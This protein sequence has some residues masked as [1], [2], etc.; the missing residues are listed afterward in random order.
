[1]RRLPGGGADLPRL[2]AT[3]HMI[4]QACSSIQMHV[5][6]AEAEKVIASLHESP[7]PYQLCQFILEN[8][9]MPNARFQAAA[10]IR[11]AALREWGLL[12]DEDKRS[13]IVFCLHF[14]MERAGASD[15]YVQSKVSAVA[16]Q[17]IKRGWQD[18]IEGDKAGVLFEVKQAILGIY[19]VDAQFVGINFLESLV[20]EFSPSTSTYMGLPKEFHELCQASFEQKYLKEF[21]F[22]G[23][24]AAVSVGDKIIG[25]A[26]IA[27]PE[28]KV[29]AAALLLMHQILNWSFKQDSSVSDLSGNKTHVFSSGIRH[30]TLLLKKFD[31]SL[32][33]PGPAWHDVLI[34]SGHTIWILNLYEVL[35]QK[36]SSDVLWIDSPL[37]ISARQLIVQLCSLSG[38]IFPSDNGQMQIKHLAQILSA[39]VKWIDPADSISASI[40]HGHSESE[41]LD[42]CHALLSI[43]TLTDCLLFDNL[44]RSIRP[45]GTLQ[46]LSTL[47]C[48]VV[49]AY[50]ASNNEDDAWSSEALDIL[51]ETWGVIL[52]RSDFTITSFSTEAVAATANLFN[53]IVESYLNA[54]AKSAFDDDNESEHFHASIS[55]RDE[56]LRSYSLI[57]RSAADVTVPFLVR[58]FSERVSLLNQKSNTDDAISLLEE[59]YWL[60]LITG[61]VLTDSGEGET[62]LVPEALQVAFSNV[63]EEAQH[64]VVVLSWSI[65]SFARQSLNPEMRT[66]FFSP[67]LMEAVVWFL[68]R[69]ADTYIMPF[70]GK[71]H[72]STPNDEP[73]VSKRVLYSFAGENDQGKLVLDTIIRISMVVL[74]SY[75]GENELQQALTCHHLLVTLVRRRNVCTHLVALESWASIA[76]AFANESSLF[77]LNARLQRSLAQA[78]VSAASGIKDPEASN[79]Y[80]RDLLGPMTTYLKNISTRNDLKAFAQQAD[81]IY[82]VIC[83][84]ERLRGAARATQPRTQVAVFEMGHAVMNSL[85]TLLEVYKNQSAVVYQIL[86]F[87]VDLV[88]AQV[89]FLNA[90]DA[91]ILVSFCLQLLKTYSSHNIGKISL[92]ISSSLHSEVQSEKYKD[93]RALLQLLTNLCSRDLVDFSSDEADGPEIAEVVYVGFH[94]V[95]PLISLDLLKYPK[96][97]FNYFSLVSHMLEVYP[98][99]V[100]RLNNEAFVH[101]VHTLDFGIRH[102]DIDVVDMCLRAVDALASYHFK[103]KIAGKEGLGARAIDSHG[104]NGELQ[105]SILKHFLRM[106]LQL[107]LFEDFRMELVGS[108]ADALLPLL[109]CEHDSYQRM[110]QELV[111]RGLNP[112]TSIRL[113]NALQCLISSNQLT[114]CLDRPNRQRF[115]KNLQTFLTDISGYMRIK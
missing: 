7:M 106:L 36:Y 105:E 44:L 86:K 2:Q 115:R 75:P 78:L 37:A 74:L 83:M 61:H 87:V 32:V 100:A 11:D 16:A 91:S 95:T 25:C 5:N 58:L 73:Q 41:M 46:L 97:S 80:V 30:D 38:S 33:Q 81:A 98:E 104:T 85:L 4:E 103:E 14:V 99:K 55:R 10:A 22:W 24:N 66:S 110:V 90:K 17:L 28:T 77:Q 39:I 20:S 6:P 79:Q 89:T 40:I 18:F 52:G 19:G 8:S 23:Q 101:T 57:A 34:S 21:Y 59:L 113:G 54:A 42:G 56:M 53:V 92:S 63:L 27:M 1:M 76:N 13:L 69:W 72:I 35:R 15:P 49:K 102:Q 48:E 67:R 47:T 68:A 107:L 64:P 50:T 112:H 114:S 93:L 9:H 31:R 96:L 26:P 29:C 84:M 51:L 62:I 109:S 111:E 45:F 88:A 108:M 82:M 65:I 71:G 3:M 12:T 70:H 94:T 60:L 43:A